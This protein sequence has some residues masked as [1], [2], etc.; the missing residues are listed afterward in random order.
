[1]SDDRVLQ[2]CV[3]DELAF[4]PRVDAAHIGV[5]ARDGIVTLT[6]HA[7]NYAEK[8]AAERAAR[9]V[10]GVKA[11]AQEIN[12]RL[13]S[14]KKTADDEIAARA[15]KILD[16]DVVI[17]PGSIRVKVENGDMTLSGEVDW[18]YQRA[19]AEDDV[20]R[21]S[22]IN[23]IINQ[24]RVRP[25]AEPEDVKAK[26]AAAFERTAEHDATAITIDILNGV[27]SLGGKVQS[28]IERDEA[29][30][31]AW[32]VPGVTAVEDHLLIERP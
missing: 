7:K 3:M 24:I 12:V 16:W 32:S 15:V 19:A 6:G 14:E 29:L 11:V 2:Q 4:D 9:R 27:V 28:W 5:T 25:H 17:P 31:A 23:F 1:M 10:R 13:P 18:V 20:R 21:L 22:G 30:R 8:F 26:I